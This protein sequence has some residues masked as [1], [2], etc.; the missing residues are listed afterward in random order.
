MIL[1]VGFFSP[2]KNPDVLFDAWLSLFERGVRS[3][4][5]LVG[6]TQG[7]YYEIDA[8][9]ADRIKSKV[10]KRGVSES[11]VFVEAADNIEHYFRAADVFVLPTARE[12]LPNVLL[13]AM[14]SGV[15][16]VIT[17]LEGVT[18]WIV[19]P[20]VTGELVPAVDST[21]F[22]DAIE[23]LLAS[24]ERREAMGAA[25]RAHVAQHFSLV[26][27]AQQDTR[28]LPGALEGT[29]FMKAMVVFGTRPEAIKL[30]PV[31]HA[32]RQRPEV[33]LR[34]VSTSQHRELLQQ[35]LEVFAITPD[36]DLSVMRPG[37][38]LE[39]LTVRVLPAMQQ[40]LAV[41]QPDVLIVQGDTTTVFVASLAAFY[42]QI[43]VAHV[44]AG[45]RSHNNY[46]PFPE[47]INRRLTSAIAALHFAPTEL[48][49]KNLL[50]ENIPASHVFVTG[51]TVVDA[52]HAIARSETFAR[53]KVP[54]DVK[55]KRLLLVTLHR[56]ESFGGALKD[57]CGALR[58]IT[59]RH[60]DVH[61][62]IPVHRNPAVK[63][64]VLDELS[65]VE[66]VSLLE[67][68]DYVSFL[69]TMEA[70]TFV[71]TDSGGVQEEAPVFGRPVLVLR[72]TTERQEAID[73]G[74]ARLVGT[75]GDDIVRFASRLLDDPEEYAAM[76]KGASPFGDGHASER[77]ADLLVKHIDPRRFS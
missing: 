76:S 31:I 63:D 18:D 37:Q 73:A 51:N 48:A 6:A 60:P 57:M 41:E 49:R 50:A 20:G 32:L 68:L 5:V 70:S 67:P 65:S 69:R 1:F 72:E 45:L 29:P 2:E 8:G 26:D 46:N 38:T 22:A 12:G 25:A 13:E 47:E 24:R 30:A 16:P 11:V 33:T 71:L 75:R 3:T 44:E 56:R 54:V 64:T 43:P 21:A 9:I 19:T 74:V 53:T 15:P 40:T 34:I 61:V 77:I 28:G 7:P 23:G 59:S 66:R 58:T 52:L 62:V 10:A 36:I 14:A 17:R 55:G 35:A 4:L 27:T 42:Q 39:E